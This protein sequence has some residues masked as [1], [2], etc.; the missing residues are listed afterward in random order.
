MHVKAELLQSWTTIFCVA[1]YVGQRMEQRV[2][3]DPKQFCMVPEERKTKR[4]RW[5]RRR[6]ANLAKK[7]GTILL[8]YT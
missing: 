3:G 6:W 7:L 4:G 5:G 1:V 2:A 8:V